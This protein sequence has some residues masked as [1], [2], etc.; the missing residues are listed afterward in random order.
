[1]MFLS[2]VLFGILSGFLG[3]KVLDCN[4]IFLFAGIAAISSVIPD[5]DHLYSKIS[6]KLPPF[7]IVFSVLFKHRGLIH[8]LWPPLL[9]YIALR[10]V[11]F[12]VAD[13]FLIGYI[14]HLLLDAT[15]TRGIRF[16]YPLP[17]KI[18]GFIRTNSFLE[19]I[20][21]LLLLTSVIALAYLEIQ[22]IL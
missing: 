8:S 19:R 20:I 2:H 12:L 9:L 21:T 6:R 11:S 16:F 1:M 7:A 4:N 22:Q 18:K 13:A 15:T 10:P 5:I 17:F 3:C 14:S